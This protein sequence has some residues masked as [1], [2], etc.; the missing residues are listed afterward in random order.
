M[1]ILIITQYFWPENFRINDL[2]LSL[3]KRGHD[4]TVLTGLP[5]YPEGHLPQGYGILNKRIE[6]FNGIKVI[7]APHITRGKKSK[8][9]LA[10]NYLSFAFFASI[11][12]LF[13]S[14]RKFDLIF[15]YEPSPITVGLP[16]IV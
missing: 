4:I 9:R 5:N 11:V 15:V 3:K 12:A 14:R 6:Y 1:N 8:L 16:A 7:R 13:F 2:T 10:F